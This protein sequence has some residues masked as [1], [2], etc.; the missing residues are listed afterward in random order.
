MQRFRQDVLHEFLRRQRAN[1]RR[2]R[3][4]E[5]LFDSQLA[6][7]AQRSPSVGKQPRR[8]LRRDHARRMRIEGQ[9]GRPQRCSR[10]ASTTADS[11]W[12]WPACTPSKLP[13]VTAWD[14]R[15]ASSKRA[16][17]SHAIQFHRVHIGLHVDFQPVVGQ[18]HMRG[19]SG[20]GALMPQIVAHV[21]EESP[22]RL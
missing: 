1:F 15:A 13:M 17:D 3:Q 14:E 4:D 7:R 6:H 10:A 2:E 20:L 11:R 19:Q 12:R 16:R 5:N 18:P 8:A 22:P 21:R 9:H